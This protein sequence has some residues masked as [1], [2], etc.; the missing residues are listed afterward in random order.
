MVL[1][2]IISPRKAEKKWWELFFIGFLYASIAIFLSI[3]IFEQYASLVM[4]FLTVTASVPLMYNTMRYEE[5]E[6]VICSTES[7]RMINH[8]KVLRFLIMLFLGFVLAY[9]IFYVFLPN[10]IVQTV[11]NSQTQTIN[12]INSRVAGNFFNDMQIFEKIFLNNI[13]V[14]LFCIFFAFFYGAGAIFILTWNASVISAA[15]G[16]IIRTN[17][18]I[19]AKDF[20]LLSI[21]TYFSIFSVGILRYLIH[22]IPEIL[23]YFVGGLAG[24]IISVAMINH[25]LDTIKFKKVLIDSI[26]LIV[27]AVFI[28]LIAAL[29]EVF[30]TP[31]LF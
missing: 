19:Y 18:A 15:I 28:L 13:K 25:D 17:L 12:S 31:L 6:D 29:M 10:D 2:S 3:W 8:F 20:G 9:T 7:K 1:E 4:V 26:Y 22:G 14:L 5:H 30:L 11:F 16:N 23:G 21:W 27:L 24:G